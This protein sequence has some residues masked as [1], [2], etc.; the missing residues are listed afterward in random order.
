MSESSPL[1]VCV[2]GAVC[3]VFLSYMLGQRCSRPPPPGPV[4]WPIIGN[5]IDIPTTEPQWMVFKRWGEKWGNIL[6]I[7]LLGQ[8]IVILNTRKDVVALFEKRSSNYSDRPTLVVAGQQ[9]GWDRA[10]VLCRYGDTWREQRRLFTELLGTRKALEQL[11][12]VIED[13][14]RRLLVG[15]LEH[16]QDLQQQ[17]YRAATASSLRITHGHEVKDGGDPVIQAIGRVME[18]FSEATLP[19]R[20]LVDILPVLQYVPAWL[21]GGGWKKTVAQYQTNV[22]HFHDLSYRF[23][24]AELAAG[25]AIPS[26]FTS[27]LEPDMTSEEEYN[28]KWAAAALFA[29]STDTIASTMATFFLAMTCFPDVQLKAQREIDAVVGT[30]RLPLASDHK[31]L[32]YISAICLEILRWQ[33]AVPLGAPRRSIEDDV[34]NGYFLPKG[35]TF[36]PNTWSILHDSETYPDPF[37]FNPNRFMPM[38]GKEPELDPRQIAFG[39]GRR[40]CPGLQFADWSIFVQCAMA[41]AVF[42][43]SKVVENGEVIEPKIEYT[44]T[45]ISHPLPWRYSLRPRSAK[46]EALV[47]QAKL[48]YD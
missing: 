26:F 45:S 41:L 25:A 9:V 46:T 32:P 43:I 48:A 15:L 17:L 13:Q 18:D 2:F 6:S 1:I 23:A 4:G 5:I 42:D 39:F 12:P 33:P 40:I 37:T 10:G 14:A 29:A 27:H 21:P 24:K 38:D 35:T 44:T 36:M 11:T 7:S 22:E 47:R 19:G 20:F 30:D 16:P 3:A 34:Y 28:L 8:R 31:Q